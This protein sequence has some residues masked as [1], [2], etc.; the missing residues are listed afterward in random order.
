MKKV[1]PK[2]SPKVS[3]VVSPEVSRAVAETLSAQVS[4]KVA[5]NAT[6]TVAHKT[7]ISY[8]EPS[9]SPA[10]RQIRQQGTNR[11]S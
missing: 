9:S 4:V 10:S 5:G 1:S 8:P 2:V 11:P 6:E 7:E 3:E